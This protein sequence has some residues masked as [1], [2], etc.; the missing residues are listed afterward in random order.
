MKKAIMLTHLNPQLR[1]IVRG[2]VATMIWILKLYD[3]IYQA[4]FRFGEKSYQ[5]WYIRAKKEGGFNPICC[6]DYESP[7]TIAI[8]NKAMIVAERE[9]SNH[10]KEI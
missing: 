9:E 10:D 6:S 5:L 8:R 1:M 7:N 4:S 2:E 3:D